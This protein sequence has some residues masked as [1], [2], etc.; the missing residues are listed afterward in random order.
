MLC[1]HSYVSIKDCIG[2]FLARTNVLFCNLKDCIDYNK[3]ETIK[4]DD[5]FRSRVSGKILQTCFNRQD[6]HPT[7]LQ[8]PIIPCMIYLWSDN[9]EP[10]NSNKSNRQ[11]V[12][13]ISATLSFLSLTKNVIQQTYPIALS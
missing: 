8:F 5:I 12:W 9:F 1:N 3:N 4:F 7:H 13:I 2:D 10:N 6:H 11:S